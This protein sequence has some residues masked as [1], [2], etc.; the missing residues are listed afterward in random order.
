MWA[1]ETLA[2]VRQHLWP[3]V[4]AFVSPDE[5]ETVHLPRALFDQL[6]NALAFPASSLLAFHIV[7]KVYLTPP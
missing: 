4:S 6:V 2:F 7:E 1:S 3:C 5:G